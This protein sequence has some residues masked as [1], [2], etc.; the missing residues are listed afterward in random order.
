MALT[1]V[2]IELSSTPSIVD[3]GNATAITI[4]SSENI[5]LGLVP[6]SFANRTSLDIGLGGKIWGHTSATE[7]GH[8]SNFYFDGAYKRIAAVAPTRHVQ[9]GNGH[10]FS[11]A[12]SG[13]ADSTITWNDALIV[14]PSGSLLIN[15]IAT[16]DTGGNKLFINSG[17][18]AAP[19]TS[20]TTQT[21]GALRLRGANNAVLDMGLNSVQTWIQATD[22]ANLANK[23]SLSLNPNGGDVGIGLLTQNHR[24]QVF[25][26]KAGFA[27]SVFES[28]SQAANEYGIAL[29]LANDP[30]DGTRYFAQFSGGTTTRCKIISNGDLLNSNN[31]YTGISDV[32]LKENI[33][34]AGSQWDDI[35]A[36]TVR[37]YS[38]KEENASEPTQIGVIA[39]EVEAAGMA[40]LVYESPDQI[41]AEDGSMEDTGEVTKGMKY[42]ILYMKAIKALQEAM[43]R[44]ETLEA[45]VQT[46]ENT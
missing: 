2:P 17:V 22:K 15:S 28:N 6:T 20:G 30:N 42:S 40:G 35:K 11:V 18:N 33:V 8:G 16:A 25:N 41:K 39:Q 19:V 36:L 43:E 24:F 4:D 3:G 46:L 37:K 10:T 34:D 9:D 44:I 12:A 32:K 29:I 31:S 1:E 5:G 21:G 23:Y 27:V 14:S 45:K 7:T 13:D 38:F 26:N